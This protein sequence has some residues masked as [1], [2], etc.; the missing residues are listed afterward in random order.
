M[1][2]TTDRTAEIQKELAELNNTLKMSVQKAIRI[3]ELLTEQ[4]EIVGHGLFIAWVKDNLDISFDTASRYIKLF[5]SGD[6]IRNLPNL[7][8]AYKQIET[9]EAQ[10]KQ[11]R[12]ERERAMI[13]EYRKT[14]KKPIGWTRELDYR[15][16]KDAEAESKQIERIEKERQEREQRGAQ[17]KEQRESL[18]QQSSSNNLADAFQTVA[19][20]FIEKTNQRNEWKEKIR[21]SAG[22]K[23]DAFMDAIIDYMETLENDN[24]RIE[25]CNNIIKICRNISVELQ[26]AN[27]KG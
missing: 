13:A 10:A 18:K 20:A 9:L 21:L 6:K 3:G 7:Q 27:K 4:K 11:S 1:K 26:R 17:Y 22:G 14:G 15:I 12:D 5:E 23:E 19:G 25:A 2:L 24:R 16:K 8:A